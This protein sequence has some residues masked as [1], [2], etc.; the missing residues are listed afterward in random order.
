MPGF[1]LPLSNTSI[2]IWLRLA[3]SFCVRNEQYVSVPVLVTSAQSGH[4]Q[5]HGAGRGLMAGS[6]LPQGFTVLKEAPMLSATPPAQARQVQQS[7]K[8]CCIFA[9]ST[10]SSHVACRTSPCVANSTGQAQCTASAEAPDRLYALLWWAGQADLQYEYHVHAMHA[11]LSQLP[12]A[13]GPDQVSRVRR[14]T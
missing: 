10:S 3:V 9:A 14:S 7:V 1:T 12:Q 11:G 6:P 2:F 4:V 8:Q 5:V 13:V